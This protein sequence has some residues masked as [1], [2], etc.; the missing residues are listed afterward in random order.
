MADTTAANTADTPAPVADT[1]ATM[2]DTPAPT[3][4]TAPADGEEILSL[5]GSKPDRRDQ[6]AGG[7]GARGGRGRG[8]P[9]GGG[10]KN[11]KCAAL[12]LA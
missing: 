9:R 2:A 4:A 6:R 8:G 12:P 5:N 11:R 10:F 7:R 1:P 3:A